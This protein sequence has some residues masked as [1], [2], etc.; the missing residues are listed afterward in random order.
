M[1]ESVLQDAGLTQNEIKVYLALLRIGKSQTG[2][3]ITESKISSGKIYDTLSKLA[4]KGLV[5]QIIENNIKQFFASHPNSLLLYMQEREELAAKKTQCIREIVPELELLHMQNTNEGSVFLIKGLRGIKPIIY[6]V[7]ENSRSEIKI[8]GV[9]SSK[10][11]RFN[12]FWQ[13]WHNERVALR[14]KAKLLFSDKGSKYWKFFDELKFTSVRV[15]E[16]MSPSAIMIIDKHSFIF[17]Y[18]NNEMSC[19]HSTSD[20]VARSFESFFDSLWKIG[21][22]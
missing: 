22:N 10:E 12:T 17:T 11:T 13:H 1:K 6:S 16:K 4:E 7:L 18:E 20:S 19:I 5:E 15:I 9:R 3:I 2:K 21:R 8:M 14:R